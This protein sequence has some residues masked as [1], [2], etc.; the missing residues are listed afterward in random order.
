M[1]FIAILNNWNG[2]TNDSQREA[3]MVAFFANKGSTATTT[4]SG[5]SN[6]ELSDKEIMSMTVPELKLACKERKIK[7]ASGKNKDV[8][9]ELLKDYDPSK[10][11][12]KS[13]KDNTKKFNI[14]TDFVKSEFVEEFRSKPDDIKALQLKRACKAFDIKDPDKPDKMYP[15]FGKKKEDMIEV[16]SVHIEDIDLDQLKAE[17]ELK[18]TAT[19]DE[20]S[21]NQSS[22]DDSSESEEDKPEEKPVE[23]SKKKSKKKRKKAKKQ[24]VEKVAEEAEEVDTDIAEP[25]VPKPHNRP[26]RRDQAKPQ[27]KDPPPPRNTTADLPGDLSDSPKMA[28]GTDSED[29]DEE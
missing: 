13:D 28:C 3:F 5:K 27:N 22:D 20:S 17:E 26:K 4:I 2:W 9:Q 14:D 12:K 8:L 19:S 23:K 11:K 21:T 29:S 18:Q 24:Q 16:L 10:A 25:S 15:S 1:S 6:D 7:G